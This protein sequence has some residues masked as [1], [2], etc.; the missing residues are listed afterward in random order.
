MLHGL[1]SLRDKGV[2]LRAVIDGGACVGDWT[3]LLKKV[4]PGAQVL[5]VEPQARHRPTLDAV[6]KGFGGSVSAAHVLLGPAAQKDVPFNVLDDGAGGTGSSVLAELSDVRR[7][8]VPTPMTTLDA[9]TA[10]RNFPVPD[11]IKLDVQ[12]FEIEA[13]KGASRLLALVP[14]VLLEVS[15]QQYNEGSPLMHDVVHWMQGAGF[16]VFDVFDLTRRADGGLLQVDLLFV[17]KDS[18]LLSPQPAA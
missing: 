18:S 6:C 4:Y 9:L 3:R 8:V 5:M 7:N 12:G 14:L 15:V 2:D 17:R 16:Q 11:L 1:L 10:G 13:L